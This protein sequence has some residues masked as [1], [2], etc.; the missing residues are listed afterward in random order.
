MATVAMGLDHF[1]R[2]LHHDKTEGSTPVTWFRVPQLL[3]K[4]TNNTGITPSL[5]SLLEMRTLCSYCRIWERGR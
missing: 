2:Y 4:E 1:Q 5:R 3:L